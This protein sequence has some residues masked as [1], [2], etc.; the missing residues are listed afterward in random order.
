MSCINVTVWNEFRHEKH[1]EGIKKI[2]PD[3][4]HN[5]IKNYSTKSTVCR[6][7]RY[8]TNRN[9]DLPTKSSTRPMLCSGGAIWLTAKE[10]TL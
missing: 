6:P 9:T 8:L 7:H 5:A 2:Y 4:I 1:D 3:G 10:T